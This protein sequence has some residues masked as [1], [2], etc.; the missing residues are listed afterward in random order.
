MT[1]A[2]IYARVSASYQGVQR[3]LNE[4]RN[5][6]KEQVGADGIEEYP[7]I[8]S[9]TTT[10]S[11]REVYDHLWDDISNG[12]FDVVAVHEISRLSRLGGTKL[13]EFIQHYLGHNIAVKSLDVGLSPHPKILKDL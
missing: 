7:E 11:E 2:T 8:V 1:Q 3:H 13:Y 9:G 12:E 4:T 6:L 5:Y 10:S